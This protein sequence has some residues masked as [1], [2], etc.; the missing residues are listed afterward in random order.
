MMLVPASAA[1]R[2]LN[3]KL[4]FRNE[5]GSLRVCVLEL[6]GVIVSAIVFSVG[7]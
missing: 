4:A 2:S 6:V 5:R 1:M 7:L 3:M